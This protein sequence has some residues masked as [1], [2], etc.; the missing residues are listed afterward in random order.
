MDGLIN[1]WIDGIK[2]AEQTNVEIDIKQRQ[3]MRYILTSYRK[4]DGLI[5]RQVNRQQN[6]FKDYKI[7]TDC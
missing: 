2:L 4:M 3:I 5:D 7:N 1:G 6:Q